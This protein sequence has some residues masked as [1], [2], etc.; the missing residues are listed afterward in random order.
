M[1]FEVKKIEVVGNVSQNPSG[2]T[3]S[4]WLNITVGVVGCPH[5]DINTT[6]TI[7][8]V[9]SNDLTVA[10]ARAGIA[11]FAAEWRVINYPNT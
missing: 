6:K 9:F 4:Q 5:N 10:E 1:E 8:Y 7:E 11:V 2:N 3:S